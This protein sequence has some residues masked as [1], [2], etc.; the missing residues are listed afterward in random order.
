MPAWLISLLVELLVQFLTALFKKIF[1][2]KDPAPYKG[3]FMSKVKWRVWYG[4]NRMQTAEAMYDKAVAKYHSGQ[5]ALPMGPW[6]ENNAADLAK[7]LCSDL[8]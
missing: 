3:A 5:W 4:P 7:Q 6:N 8:V 2:A 1:G